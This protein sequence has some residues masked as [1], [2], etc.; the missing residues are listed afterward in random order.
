MK[1]NYLWI[2]VAF[3]LMGTMSASAQKKLGMRME[4][5]ESETDHGDYSI[6]TYTD[7]DGTLGYYMGVARTSDILAGGEILGVTGKNIKETAIWLGTTADEAFDTIDSILALYDKDV[8]TSTEFK[9]R[10]TNGAGNLGEPST[11]QCVVVKK[12]LGGKRL[13]FLFT[14]GEKQAHAYLTKST[15]KE[16]RMN[17]KMDVK[18]HPK[19]YKK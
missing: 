4:I 10:D 13:E 2:L 9:S 12:P 11:S 18:L 6:F 5:A 1:K 7:E 15:V 14:V 16:L 3:L 19:R 8:D 17:F